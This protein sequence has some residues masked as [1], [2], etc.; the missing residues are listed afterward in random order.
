MEKLQNF[1]ITKARNPRKSEAV[2]EYMYTYSLL[3]NTKKLYK[4]VSYINRK[5]K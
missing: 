1:N 2:T 4:Q 3:L 5:V